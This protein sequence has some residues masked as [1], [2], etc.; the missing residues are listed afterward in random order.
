MPSSASPVFSSL[1]FASL[2]SLSLTLTARKFFGNF[3]LFI[4]SIAGTV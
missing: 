2:A 1:L 4:I 3:T